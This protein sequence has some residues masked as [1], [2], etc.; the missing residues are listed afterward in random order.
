MLNSNIIPKFASIIFW[1][2]LSETGSCMYVE[3]LQSFLFSMVNP[4]REAP[5]KI[6]LAKRQNAIY[7]K[8]DCGPTFG[9][10]HDLH[11]SNN[12]DTSDKSYSNLGITYELPTGQQNKIFTG[13]RNFKVTDFEVFGI[14]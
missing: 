13:T 12:A 8:S 4:Q 7:C 6:L 2:F 3:C 10:G 5:L 14:C 9:R 1:F 11:I